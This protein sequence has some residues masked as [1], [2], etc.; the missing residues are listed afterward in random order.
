[1]ILAI[2]LLL[3][4]LTISAVAIYYSVA[5]L[6]A[7]FS[8]AAIPIIVMGVSLEVGKLVIAS[9]V[10]ARWQQ[11]PMLMRGYAIFAVIIL[12]VITSLGI[13][14]FL[15]K[16]H[17]DQTLVSGDVQGK[18]AIYD[19]RIKTAKE[20]IESNRKQ[21]KQ[22]D[23]AVDQI[24]A[25][26]TSEGGA[27]KAN[28]VRK[29]QLKDRVALNKDIEVQQ[30]L[31]VKLNE[32]AAPIR[33][34]VR[35]VEAEVGPLKYIAA[36]IYGDNPDANLLERAVTWVIILIVIV[37]DPLA[38]VM[39]LAAQMTFGWVKKEKEATYEPDDG[40]L[41]DNQ[42]TQLKETVELFEEPIEPTQVEP[43][44]VLEV[45]TEVDDPIKCYKCDTPLADAPGIG[46]F[47]PNK[48]CDVLDGPQN[49]N[50]KPVEFTVNL[51]D[52]TPEEEEAFKTLENKAEQLKTT[53]EEPVAPVIIDN[54]D[55]SK[56]G[57]FLKQHSVTIREHVEEPV[58][59]E[60]IIEIEESKEKDDTP[61]FEGFRD[62]TTGEWVQ[63]GP[64]FEAP[65][66]DP[67]EVVIDTSHPYSTVSSEYVEYEG[68]RMHKRVLAEL[69][70]DLGILVDNPT[71]P[72][73]SFG[74]NFPKHPKLGDMF[75]RVDVMPHRIF[76]FN[77]IKWIEV[78]REKTDSHLSDDNYIQHLIEKIASGEYDPEHLTPAEQESIAQ[79]IKDDKK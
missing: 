38:I 44:A 10:K 28:A 26:S 55:D 56:S 13:F 22:M 58:I 9:W 67:V 2:L 53:S 40:P 19:E 23:E 25:R 68:K 78:N 47:C 5:G 76:K 42:I 60:P 66:A 4:G 41:T 24:M 50:D 27:D 32:E 46:L 61:N 49:P 31:V 79:Y 52:T 15:S 59:E 12:M 30:K 21:L 57:G 35:K 16:A 3:S 62:S 8:A 77:G 63:T 11:V 37:F 51:N 71:S 33:A 75:T 14:G 6:V 7:I 17:S 34:E 48:E 20:N 70:P 73:V 69:R 29:G 36:F 64:S 65:V 18:I 54:Q 1:M 39:L 72:D 45:D 43:N 74:D